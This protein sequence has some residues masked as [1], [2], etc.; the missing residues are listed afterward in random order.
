MALSGRHGYSGGAVTAEDTSKP[1]DDIIEARDLSCWTNLLLYVILAD[2]QLVSKDYSA[3]VH[4]RHNGHVA[5]STFC[6]LFLLYSSCIVN[7]Q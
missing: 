5:M 4:T 7:L 2:I 1:D 6:F 3:Y